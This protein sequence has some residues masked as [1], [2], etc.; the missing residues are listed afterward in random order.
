[1]ATTTTLD[2]GT[3]VQPAQVRKISLHDLMDALTKGIDDFKAKPSLAPFAAGIYLLASFL[4]F[5]VVANYDYLPL[6]FPVVSGAVLIGPFVTIAL[7]EVSRRRERGLEYGL[8]TGYNFFNAPAIK[9]VLLLGLMMVALFL[10]WLGAAMTIYGLTMGDEW[11]AP[12]APAS[13]AAFFQQLLFT[14]EGWTMIIV[15]NIVGLLFAVVSLC[16]AT[17]SFPM[18]LD[19]HT[20][21]G[22]AVM[23]SIHAV[24]ENPVTMA[25]WGL[26]VVVLLIAGAVP[27]F[28]GLAVVIP[29]L[30]HAT[31][32]LYRKVV[33]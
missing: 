4:G 25:M 10:L 28:A 16:A 1:M 32:H 30:G 27:F 20:N 31:W 9:D 29:V 7:C 21:I 2:A 6:V 18:L 15:G 23:T 24:K 19:R 12:T 14:S 5:M 17:V 33:V 11:R 13:M 3:V 26:I 22:S 8:M